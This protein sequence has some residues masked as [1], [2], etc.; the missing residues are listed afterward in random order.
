MKPNIE[1][2]KREWEY[3]YNVAG[4][5][6][7]GVEDD[8]I[9]YFRC[10]KSEGIDWDAGCT[11]L[12]CWRKYGEYVFKI[13]MEYESTY[14][15]DYKVNYTPTSEKNTTYDSFTENE[16]NY[17]KSACAEGLGDLFAW[18]EYL[19]AYRIMNGYI[20]IYTMERVDINYDKNTAASK[21]NFESTHSI[22]ECA[23]V[24]EYYFSDEDYMLALAKS[25]WNDDALFE[26]FMEF[27]RCTEINDLH[28]GNWG[29]RNGKLIVT[30][31]AGF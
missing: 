2:A 1:D 11:R 24:P 13:D 29:R 18:E 12:V 21:E 26:E 25:E 9:N 3:I 20:H 23:E 22:E 6:N 15:G 7:V 30:D 5:A 4:I 14:N 10:L 27:I 28:A 19:G 8:I 17:Y 16:L 31:Y